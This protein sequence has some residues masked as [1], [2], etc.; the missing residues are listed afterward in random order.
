[1]VKITTPSSG[2]TYLLNTLIPYTISVSDKEDG[3]SKYEEINNLEVFLSVRYIQDASQETMARKTA[4]EPDAPGF[5]LLQ[6]S[7]CITCHA[8]NAPL[9]GPAFT[10]I[11]RRYPPSKP[12]EIALAKSVLEGSSGIWGSAV[13][14]SHPDLSPETARQIVAWILQNAGDP[15]SNYYSGTAGALRLTIPEGVDAGGFFILRASYTDHG[16]D[17]RNPLQG[18]DVVLLHAK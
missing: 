14:P 11:T 3:E 9:I 2:R 5:V 18:D 1:M 16:I 17:N 8:F 6:K 12:N 7:N 4:S 15:K 10:E 13:M